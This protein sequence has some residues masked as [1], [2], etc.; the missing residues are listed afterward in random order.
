VLASDGS[1]GAGWLDD[2][3]WG[4]EVDEITIRTIAAEELAAFSRA[5]EPAFGGEPSD[6]VL[7][8]RARRLEPDRCFVAVAADG[9]FVATGGAYS[10]DLAL[11]AAAPVGCAGVTMVSVRTDH[12][13]RGL[14]TR[15]IAALYDQ[16]R[17]RGEPFAALWAS[18][19][20]IYGRFG[21]GPAIP[22]LEVEV[23]RDHARMAV[24]ATV[25]QVVLVDRDRARHEFPAI[26]DAVR[27]ERTG[28]LSRSDAWWD[29][30]L[31]DDPVGEREGRGPRCYALVPGRGYA[32][33]RIRPSWTDMAPDGTVLV[34]ELHATDPDAAAALWRFVTDIDLADRTVAGTRPVDEPFLAMVENTARMKVRQG[35]PLYVRVLDVPAALTAR[36][37]AEDGRIVLEVADAGIADNAGRWLLEVADGQG[38]CTPTDASAD[39]LLDVRDLATVSLGGVR[40]SQLVRA[41]RIALGG[42]G[43]AAGERFDRML[44]TPLAPYHEGMF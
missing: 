15:L 38:R 26:R 44:R 34:S 13:R 21:Y 43:P 41:G 6:H 32:I 4:T 30:I 12:R 16:A 23:R 29:T 28:M 8:Q 11:P 40:V 3:R 22:H 24:P 42:D 36:R 25:G 1:L 17:E 37:Y 35:W 39:L 5:F 33:Y 31:D 7:A 9:A 20:P 19:S 10:F 14:L 18:E 27:R 2:D